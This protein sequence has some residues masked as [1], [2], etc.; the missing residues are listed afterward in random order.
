MRELGL[1]QQTIDHLAHCFVGA[2]SID[3]DLLAE[4]VIDA[5]LRLGNVEEAVDVL[6]YFCA[7]PDDAAFW[8]KTLKSDK[9]LRALSEQPAVQVILQRASKIGPSSDGPTSPPEDDMC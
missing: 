7:T 1:Y 2:P 3:R 9:D 6:R 5:Y 8:T 4:K